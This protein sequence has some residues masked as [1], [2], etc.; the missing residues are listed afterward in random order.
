MTQRVRSR[1]SA[2]GEAHSSPR[3]D[4]QSISSPPIVYVARQPI[5]DRHQR[6]FGY[7]LLFRDGVSSVLATATGDEASSRVLANSFWVIGI[8]SITN[9]RRAFVNFTRN[10]LL[11]D[12]ATA[13]SPRLMAVEIVEDVEPDE[14][15][16]A[17]CQ[18]LKKAG[19][20]LALDDFVY[21][22]AYDDLI[23]LADIIKVDFLA[24]SVVER[25]RLVDRLQNGRLRF[26]A[27]KVETHEDFRMALDFGYSYIQ[28]H[29]L[30]RPVVL[31]GRDIPGF[32]LNYLKALYEVNLPEVDIDVLEGVIRQDLSLSYKLLRLVNSAH[33]GLPHK[34]RSIR[35][36]LMMLG[37]SEVRK[38]ASLIALS[39]LGTDKP[40]ELMVQSAIRAKFLESLAPHVGLSQQQTDLYL[41]GLFSLIDAFVDQPMQNVLKELPL[42]DSAVQALL[43]QEGDYA[44]IYKLLHLYERANWKKLHQMETQL[45]LVEDLVPDLY[46]RAV[47]WANQVFD[48]GES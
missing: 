24:T 27:E 32:K 1:F 4:R 19:Y 48:T 25:K 23:A 22:Q 5:F 47:L 35:H 15:I 39:G 42:E 31:T 11:D 16:L 26:L 30:S 45:G 43:K 8:E 41:M 12:S 3:R 44:D 29:F 46:R 10:L 6:I 9:G 33:F 14:K 34:I 38:W 2:Q 21:R 28:G 17:A 7:E 37:M 13:F 40:T 36:A 20:L 18:R